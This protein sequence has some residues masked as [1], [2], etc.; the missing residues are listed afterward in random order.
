MAGLSTA[1]LDTIEV[2][3]LAGHSGIAAVDALCGAR[4]WEQGVA[5]LATCTLAPPGDAE[6][7]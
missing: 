6:A 5:D 2:P 3:V 1:E 7:L 4:R